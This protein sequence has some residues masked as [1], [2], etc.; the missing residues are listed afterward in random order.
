MVRKWHKIVGGIFYAEHIRLPNV[1]RKQATLTHGQPNILSIE[2]A[3][4]YFKPSTH[5]WLFKKKWYIDRKCYEYFL[6][7]SIISS[8]YSYTHILKFKHL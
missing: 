6:T 7:A 5:H 1:V 4:N 3:A 8:R 2:Y